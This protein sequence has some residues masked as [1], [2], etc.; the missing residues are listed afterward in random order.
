MGPAVLA[1]KSRSAEARMGILW[2]DLQCALRELVL[3][4]ECNL[5]ATQAFY[6]PVLALGSAPSFGAQLCRSSMTAY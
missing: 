3:E 5:Q 1:S 6:P 4:N 2:P